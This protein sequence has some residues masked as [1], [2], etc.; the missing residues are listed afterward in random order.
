M[1][2]LIKNMV[3][4]RCIIVVGQLLAENGLKA[5]NILLGEVEL[6]EKPSEEQLKLF[7]YSL[8]KVGF[9]LLNDQKKQLE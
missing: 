1:K 5:N 9:E 2:L 8:Q 4:P 3:C 6:H 7:S